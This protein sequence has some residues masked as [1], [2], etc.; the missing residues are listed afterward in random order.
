MKYL[1]LF[2]SETQ[3]TAY[4]NSGDYI[5]PNISIVKGEKYVY[6]NKKSKSFNLITTYTSNPGDWFITTEHY[7]TVST[8][9]GLYDALFN[10]L[11]PPLGNSISWEVHDVYLEE[12]PIFIDGHKIN[13]ISTESYIKPTYGS[14]LYFGTIDDWPLDNYRFGDFHMWIR[15]DVIEIYVGESELGI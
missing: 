15:P 7:W 3:Y 4:K 9:E 8:P 6:F 1:K 5:T 14:T 12:N 10:N 11:I 13:Y 2:S